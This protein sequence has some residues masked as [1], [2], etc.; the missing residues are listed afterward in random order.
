VLC[1]P[2]ADVCLEACRDEATDGLGSA[3]LTVVGLMLSPVVG[4][5][6]ELIVDPHLEREGDHRRLLPTETEL[7]AT[8]RTGIVAGVQA[9]Q[10][11]VTV[12]LVAT[13]AAVFVVA[14]GVFVALTLRKF[15][16][17]SRSPDHEPGPHETAMYLIHKPISVEDGNAIVA[18]LNPA[19]DFERYGGKPMPRWPRPQRAKVPSPDEDVS[20]VARGKLWPLAWCSRRSDV[21]F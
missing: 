17:V 2:G 12:L 10:I 15:G 8:V 19:I 6:Q 16:R 9:I 7:T 14:I 3:Q 18:E 20:D 11:I 13:S 4:T 1:S 21:R 5:R